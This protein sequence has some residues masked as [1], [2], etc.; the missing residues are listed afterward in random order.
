[1]PNSKDELLR[2]KALIEEQLKW[3]EQKLD[4][5]DHPVPDQVGVPR[6]QPPPPKLKADP[7]S[8]LH[9]PAFSAEESPN[10]PSATDPDILADLHLDQ[11]LSPT[12][13]KAGCIL[14]A[15]TACAA[16]LFFIFGLPYLLD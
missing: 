6:I 1:M 16:V 2:Q 14:I 10:I 3:I 8:S 4:E 11:T 9:P 13:A 12:M 7:V 15:I 5:L